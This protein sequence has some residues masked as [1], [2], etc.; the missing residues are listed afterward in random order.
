MNVVIL[1]E[2]PERIQYLPGLMGPPTV[3]SAKI[4]IK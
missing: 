3:E 1:A 2:L 4:S